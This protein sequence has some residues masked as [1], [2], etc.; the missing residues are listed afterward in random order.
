M[1]VYSGPEIPNDNLI[2]YFDSRNTKKSW[3]GQPT[4][5]LW[6]AVANG[7]DLNTVN[8]WGMPNSGATITS[9]VYLE[10][11][12]NNRIWLVTVSIGT[13]SGF[14]SWR[15][16]LP[17][18]YDSTYGTVRRLNFKVKMLKGSLTSISA[19][20]GGGNSGHN[21]A[22]FTAIDPLTIVGT[23]PT[24]WFQFD[25]SVSG[26]YPSGHCVGV[27]ILSQDI[28]FLVTEPIVSPSSVLVAYTPTSRTN[29]QAILDLTGNNT[30][31]ATELTYN[32][33]GTFSF[34]GDGANTGNPPGDRI[35]VSSA[36]TNT[37]PTNRPNGC[38]YLWWSRISAAQP[39]GQCIL[40]GLGTV[41]H[42][43]FKN[44]GTSAPFFRTE[45]AVQN[46]YSF[47][48]GTVPGGSLVGRWACFAIVFANAEG[49][50]PVRWY[51][52]ASLF[53]TGNM[54]GGSSPTT[55][56]FFFTDIGRSTGDPT[57]LYSES[58]KGDIGSFQIYDTALTASQIRQLFDVQRSIYGI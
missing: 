21:P 9:E 24:G 1:S 54:T 34:A 2:F 58:F 3:V 48:A 41:A 53:H 11:F 45:G 40:F 20:T 4:T 29:A 10:T 42:I 14:A 36:I 43:E 51:H 31:T 8:N 30:I 55:E 49:S 38:T 44:E 32:S 18:T 52:N 47:G 25:G 6:S 46:G 33:D 16:C 39:S 12:N 7:T 13:I 19:H 56:Y 50:R 5:N 35:T 17:N 15:S 27:G 28:Q 57:F 37:S 23:D 26:S 22:N